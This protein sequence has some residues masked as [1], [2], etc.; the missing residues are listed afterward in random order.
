MIAESTTVV[1]VPTSLTL[2]NTKIKS[3]TSLEVNALAKVS[4]DPDTVKEL[5]G[6][7]IVPLRDTIIW[8]ALWGSKFTEFFCIV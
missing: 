6:A 8:L 3:M 2:P 7:C 4:V 5:T 1:A